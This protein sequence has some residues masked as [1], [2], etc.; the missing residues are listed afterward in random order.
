MHPKM[1][2]PLYNKVLDDQVGL[3]KLDYERTIRTAELLG[4]HDHE[5]ATISQ[6][7]CSSVFRSRS[8]SS[9]SVPTISPRSFR[10]KGRGGRGAGT[11]SHGRMSG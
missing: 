5:T 4:L 9:M 8:Y 2:L 11:S 6:R 10:S 1:Q 7:A 3:G